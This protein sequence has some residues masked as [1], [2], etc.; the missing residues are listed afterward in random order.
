VASRLCRSIDD[1]E[2]GNAFRDRF[3]QCL[4][5]CDAGEAGTPAPCLRHGRTL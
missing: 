4:Q 1:P 2:K 5:Q 3:K